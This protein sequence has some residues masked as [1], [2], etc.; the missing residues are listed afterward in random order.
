MYAC[1]S[2]IGNWDERSLGFLGVVKGEECITKGYAT[3][4]LD[5]IQGELI[6][7]ENGTTD[8]WPIVKDD[9]V[10]RSYEDEQDKYDD[11][12][13]VNEISSYF[14]GTPTF[15]AV[16]SDDDYVDAIFVFV[17]L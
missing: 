9:I 6:N 5:F 3:A 7:P 13:E 11:I 1:L 8:V 16:I 12:C 2:N 10:I 15:F 17:K 4:C 14:N